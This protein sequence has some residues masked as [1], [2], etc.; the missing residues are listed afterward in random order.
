M[1]IFGGFKA[2]IVVVV[3]QDVVELLNLTTIGELGCEVVHGRL[4]GVCQD[5][6][7]VSGKLSIF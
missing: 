1:E 5:R 2:G 6:V 3:E 7:D 4:F